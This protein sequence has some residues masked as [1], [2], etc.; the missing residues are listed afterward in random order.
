MEVFGIISFK[1]NKANLVNKKPQWNVRNDP[2]ALHFYVFID[3]GHFDYTFIFL[4][5]CDTF[6]FMQIEID[7][8]CIYL[9]LLIII[10]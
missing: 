10:F 4:L 2:F 9:D 5:E 8:M 6:I 7:K 1:R 3:L